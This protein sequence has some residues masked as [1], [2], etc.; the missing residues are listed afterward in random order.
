MYKSRTLRHFIFSLFRELEVPRGDS[1]SR[2]LRLHA[3]AK[4]LPDAKSES[5]R[6]T[7]DIMVLAEE[8]SWLPAETCQQIEQGGKSA[9]LGLF[10]CQTRNMGPTYRSKRKKMERKRPLLLQRISRDNASATT[11]PSR[12][13]NNLFSMV[14]V[15]FLHE[16]SGGQ[17]WHAHA[18]SCSFQRNGLVRTCSTD[19][20]KRRSDSSLFLATH[21]GNQPR[22]WNR[23]QLGQAGTHSMEIQKTKPMPVV[24]YDYEAICN[25]YDR[26]PLQVG[27]RL[28]SLG[29]PLLG[30]L[31]NACSGARQCLFGR[32]YSNVCPLKFLSTGWYI[33]LLADRTMGI[34]E[35]ESV[36]RKRGEE[37]R[38]HLVRS[39]SV[40]L[41]KVRSI[42]ES[43]LPTYNAT[44]Q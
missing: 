3:D 12:R 34:S 44:V 17:Y 22:T 26:R 10:S 28:N 4:T 33:R 25:F 27:W 8:S 13:R 37:L 36:Q 11:S 1:R 9:N 39:G 35:K 5:A 20:C 41:I 2:V 30:E 40:T 29:L 31:V 16:L 32:C 38:L 43:G 21:S 6:I 24:G 14:F 15:I 7:I 23:K 42:P 19:R 18:F